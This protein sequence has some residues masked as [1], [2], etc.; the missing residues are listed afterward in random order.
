MSQSSQ[1]GR[2]KKVLLDDW[3]SLSPIMRY[4]VRYVHE[5]NGFRKMYKFATNTSFDI[6]FSP[7]SI[8]HF[9]DPKSVF[10]RSKI[11]LY[12]PLSVIKYLMI[13]R[14]DNLLNTHGIH[15]PPSISSPERNFPTGYNVYESIPVNRYYAPNQ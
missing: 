1:F 13:L 11:N 7:S 2:V 15:A 14:G 3:V 6:D 4:D 5:N 10:E 8:I 9:Y 12:N